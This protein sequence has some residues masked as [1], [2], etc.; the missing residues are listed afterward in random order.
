MIC[1]R[2]KAA[3]ASR[4]LDAAAAE[5]IAKGFDAARVDTIARNAGI[6]KKTI[7]RCI[8]S[9]EELFAAV[10]EALFATVA[11]APIR[12]QDGQRPIEDRLRALL[13]AFARLAFSRDGIGA[14][15]LVLTEAARFPA[16]GRAYIDALGHHWKAALAGCLQQAADAGAIRLADPA[17]A[18]AMLIA[19]VLADPM[20]DVALGL[21]DPP[22]GAQVD[23]MIDAALTLFFDG[24]RRTPPANNADAMIGFYPEF[25][26]AP[27]GR[28]S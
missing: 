27:P 23:R 9:K 1:S 7:Y 20:R 2:S 14:Y 21:A 19:L 28:P 11:V 4:L 16:I 22:D 15:R 25:R 13:Q 18:A 8:A 26:V 12:A 17:A 10:V 6:S 5:F 3:A 24:C